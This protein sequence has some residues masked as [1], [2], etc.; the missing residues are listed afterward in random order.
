MDPKIDVYTVL[1][2]KEPEGIKY[3]AHEFYDKDINTFIYNGNRV[4]NIYEFKIINDKLYIANNVFPPETTY[5]KIGNKT[6]DSI[7]YNYTQIGSDF[8]I[9]R[10]NKYNI[11]EEMG[12]IFSSNN[13]ESIKSWIQKMKDFPH[14]FNKEEIYDMS[15]E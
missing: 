11:S 14:Y 6:N 3:Y 12:K 7:N 9:I 5:D 15:N 1:V 13:E 8:I 2:T 4:I 10:G